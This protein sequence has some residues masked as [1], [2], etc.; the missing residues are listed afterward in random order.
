M[1]GYKW[2]YARVVVDYWPQKEDPNRIRIAVGGN[3]ITYKGNTSTQTA[4]LTTSK[5]LWNSVLRMDG[6]RYMCI[7]IKKFYLTAALDYYEY[8]KMPLALFPVWI[9]K[10]YNLDM[11][12]RDGFVFLEI[13]RMVWGLPQAGML[14]NK[15]LWKRLKPYWY[16]ECVNTPGL[17]R[18]DTRPITSLLVVDDFGIKYVGKGHADHLINCLKEKY[19][20]TK[21]WAGDLFCSISLKWDYGVQTLDISMPGYIKK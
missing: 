21:D 10:Q 13:R 4:N 20:F 1:A 15:L 19:K 14:A 17:W 5:L 11:H 7:D 6:V 3:L 9:K 8:M 16:Y 18:H 12:A 2:S